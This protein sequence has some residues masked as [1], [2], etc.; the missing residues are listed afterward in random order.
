MN[1]DVKQ[2]N[3][4]WKIK[5]LNPSIFNMRQAGQQQNGFAYSVSADKHALTP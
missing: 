4:K 5:D 1:M 3:T 2:A